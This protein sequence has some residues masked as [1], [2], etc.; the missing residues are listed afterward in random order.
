MAGRRVR[1]KQRTR[2][3]IAQVA[4]TLFLDRGFDEVTVAEVAEAAGVSKVTVFAHFAR[5][6]DLLL[7]RAPEAFALLSAAARDRPAGV[8]PVPALHRLAVELAEQRHPLSGLT[9]GAEAF[10]RTVVSSPALLAR[11]REMVGEVELALGRALAEGPRPVVEP[12]LLASL[13]VA[14]YRTVLTGTAD[15][16]INGD[17]LPEVVADHHRRLETAF[18]ALRAAA[19][20]LAADVTA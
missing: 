14:A 7:D 2:D 10:L 13:V 20:A 18:D 3:R 11:A 15:R 5:K 9:A 6:E 8:D 4:T 12:H 16:R 19:G 1:D 17:P